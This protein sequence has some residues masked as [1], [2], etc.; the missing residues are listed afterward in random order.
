LR[1]EEGAAVEDQAQ[2][3]LPLGLALACIVIL[4]G[5]DKDKRK[6]PATDDTAPT[7]DT[8]PA[9]DTESDCDT[10]YL[11]DDGECVPAACGTGTWG[12]L[13]VDES[14]V[15]VD[16]AAGKGGD[17]SEAAPFTSIQAGLDAAGDAG[18][19]MVAV[20]AGS[21]PETLELDRGHDGVRLAGRCKELVLIDAATGDVNTPGID[22]DANSYEVE[23][24]SVTVSGSHYVGVAVGSGTMTIRDSAVVESEYYGVVAYQSGMHA[25]TLR[26]RAR[27][28]T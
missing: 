3:R 10:G 23:I 9:P 21:Y 28:T 8:G 14:T 24:S 7:H 12:N 27:I 13:E 22:V 5:C 6:K 2:G 20:A 18:G 25:T 26:A 11:E 15:Y 17:G 16:I 4:A 1:S 19:G